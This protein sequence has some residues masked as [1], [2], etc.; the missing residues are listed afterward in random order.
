MSDP[1]PR[2]G[3]NDIEALHQFAESVRRRLGVPGAAIALDRGGGASLINLG[4]TSVEDPLPITGDTLFRVASIT[5][6]LVA[7]SAVRLAE[8][9]ILNLD[10]PVRRFL[11]NFRLAEEAA[12]K[13]LTI[14]HLLTHS[15]GWQDAPLSHDDSPL[16]EILPAFANLRQEAAPG[17]LWSYSNSGFILAGLVLQVASGLPFSELIDSLIVKPLGM[18]RTCFGLET[19]ITQ[20]VAMGHVWGDTGDVADGFD[21]ISRLP[22]ALEVVRPWTNNRWEWPS[23]GLLTTANDLVRFLHAHAFAPTKGEPEVLSATAIG[24]LFTPQIDG[25]VGLSWFL[26][27]VGG[28]MTIGLGGGIMGSSAYA[29]MVP[30][31]G[32]AVVVLANL[33]G[34]AFDRDVT[35]WILARFADLHDSRP[36]RER[37]ISELQEYVGD[38]VGAHQAV[39][40]APLDGGLRMTVRR[41]SAGAGG[42]TGRPKGIGELALGFYDADRVVVREG[43]RR[44]VTGE[45]L[46]DDAGRVAWFRF[47]SLIHRRS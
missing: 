8:I 29:L 13:T 10:D 16:I 27:P 12:A 32:L 23:I 33:G 7:A 5:K 31:R 39:T 36:I 44:T 43:A 1:S 18:T 2:I 38:Y 26:N 30:S 22:K 3:T 34:H 11:P 21:P 25:Q 15:G 46:R 20:R 37:A 45:F 4:V 35:N 47:P 6:T 41:T 9:G 24:S 28:V 17:H 40:L 42:A 14:R 19:A